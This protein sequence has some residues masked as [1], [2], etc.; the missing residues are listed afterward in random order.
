MKLIPANGWR[1]FA[2][3]VGV[4]VLGVLIAL[5]AQRIVEDYSDRQRLS[6]TLDAI[7]TEVADHDFSASEIQIA[8]PCIVAQVE[9]IQQRLAAG[10]PRLVP[11]YRDADFSDGYVVR[12]PSRLWSGVAW[13]SVSEADT[14]RR[15]K[16][17]FAA[18]MAPYYA[19]VA[20]AS[21]TNDEAWAAHVSLNVLGRMVPRSES[22][23][24]RFLEL[25]GI[26]RGKIA[27]LDLVSGQ[28]RY[29][30]GQTGQLLSEKDRNAM[31]ANS[32]TLK[33]CRERGLPLGVVRPVSAPQS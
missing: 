16:P 10:D 14:L 29:R 27:F 19:Q 25:A 2:G 33:F 23:R 32:G 26:L 21:G 18:A 22:D 4:I 9:A 5:G 17:D 20:S 11:L 8:A 1:G 28:I 31:L 6:S 24:L 15:L 12:L 30:L 7:R 3:E 13:Q